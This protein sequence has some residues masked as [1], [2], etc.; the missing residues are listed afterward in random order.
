MKCYAEQQN[1]IEPTEGNSGVSPFCIATSV[2]FFIEDIKMKRIEL[3]QNQFA[4]VD[5]DMFNWLNRYKWYALWNKDTQSF[6]AAR[7]SKGE[8]DR[9]CTIP[10]AREILGLKYGDKREADHRDH[11]ILD[12]RILN[13]RVVTH[14]QNQ[15]NRKSP[16]GYRWHKSRKKYEARIKLNNK[17][18]ELGYF[19]TTTAAHNAYLK[20]KKIYHKF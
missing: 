9:R 16:K 10:M 14:Q 4:I 11:N 19:R 8:N 2:G 3:S 6:Y 17:I 7:N 5:D 13:L 20:A 1:L 18:I 12:N 15:W